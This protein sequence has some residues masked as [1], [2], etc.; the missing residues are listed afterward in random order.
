MKKLK[1]FRKTVDVA[2]SVPSNIHWF[3]KKISLSL[4]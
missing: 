2:R 3:Y 4:E 1:L